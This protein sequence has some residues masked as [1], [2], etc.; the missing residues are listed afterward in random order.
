M[1]LVVS[2]SFTSNPLPKEGEEVFIRGKV[3]RESLPIE[4]QEL[5]GFY[6]VELQQ[7]TNKTND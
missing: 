5:G 7:L 4:E 2:G 6:L 1:I 3:Q